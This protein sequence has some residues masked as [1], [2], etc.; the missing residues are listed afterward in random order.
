MHR[1]QW[2][3]GV[4]LYLQVIIFQTVID[5][6]R[7]KKEG[8]H[9]HFCGIFISTTLINDFK[10]YSYLKLFV[11]KQKHTLFQNLAFV[12]SCSGGYFLDHLSSWSIFLW[13][14]RCKHCCC[15]VHCL[16]RKMWGSFPDLTDWTS[17]LHC[18]FQIFSRPFGH[19]ISPAELPT[20]C[21]VGGDTESAFNSSCALNQRK[22]ELKS[23]K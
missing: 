9:L 7:G 19:S 18:A 14:E 4:H 21:Q 8:G 20:C 6:W 23:K 22:K 3:C 17:K 11:V 5:I 12:H 13:V 1:H 15:E 16:L 2:N 10:T